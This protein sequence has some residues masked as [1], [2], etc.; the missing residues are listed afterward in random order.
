MDG[1]GRMTVISSGLYWP[2]GL[3]IDYAT[4]RLYFADAKLDFI[5]YCNYDGSGRKRIG[6]S[7]NVSW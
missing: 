6:N 1:S 4:K 2:N 5:E 3:S 7:E